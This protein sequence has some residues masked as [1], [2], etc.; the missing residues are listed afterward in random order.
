VT[1]QEN[2]DYI[3]L[4]KIMSEAG[5]VWSKYSQCWRRE[6]DDG[7]VSDEALVDFVQCWPTLVPRALALFEKGARGIKL[8]FVDDKGDE[9]CMKLEAL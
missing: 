5:F 7:V 2:K 1:E 4:V 8:S 6:R 3:K 9:C